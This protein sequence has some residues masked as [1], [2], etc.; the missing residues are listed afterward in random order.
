MVILGFFIKFVYFNINVG[1]KN[2]SYCDLNDLFKVHILK[3]K[4]KLKIEIF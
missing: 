2:K 1:H 4:T 3:M